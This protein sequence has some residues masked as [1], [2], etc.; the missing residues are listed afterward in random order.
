MNV[1]SPRG[2]DCDLSFARAQEVGTLASASD[3][4][5]RQ[6]LPSNPRT[7]RWR[8]PGPQP[9]PNRGSHSIPSRREIDAGHRVSRLRA[10]CAR[11]GLGATFDGEHPKPIDPEVL[12][13][14]DRVIVTGG[15]AQVD[16]LPGMVGQIEVWET[17]EPSERGIEGMERMRLV[18]DDLQCQVYDLAVELLGRDAVA[19]SQRA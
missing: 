3:R 13:R 7:V 10:K 6:P 9:P 18:R 11:R 2:H 4:P 19:G 5:G 12:A 1:V 16:A 8:G 14:V 15:D 17:D